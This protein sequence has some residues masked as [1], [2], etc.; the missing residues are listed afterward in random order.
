VQ[1]GKILR[2]LYRERAKEEVGDKEGVEAAP[3]AKL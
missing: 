3:R 2:R 1:S